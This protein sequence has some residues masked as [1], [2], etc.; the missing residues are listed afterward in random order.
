MVT[1]NNYEGLMQYLNRTELKDN[2]V[3]RT[4]SQIYDYSGNRECEIAIVRHLKDREQSTYK[5]V[6]DI[7]TSDFVRIRAYLKMVKY[8]G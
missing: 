5:Y 1:I 8:G 6:Y 3:K 2:D 4:Y 7:G